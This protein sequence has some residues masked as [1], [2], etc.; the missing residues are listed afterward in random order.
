MAPVIH[1][2]TPCLNTR[3]SIDRTILSV[4]TQAGDFSIRYHIQDGGSSDGNWERVQWWQHKMSSE[5][6]PIQCRHINLTCA[7][8]DDVGMYDAIIKG[9]DHTAARPNDFLT[10]INAD[11]V[12]LPGALAFVAN[13]DRQFRPK[14][15]AWLGGAVSITRHQEFWPLVNYDRFVSTDAIKAGLCDGIHLDFVQ[16]EG[17]FYRKWLW[18]K[19]DPSASLRLMKIGGDWNAWRLMA[20]HA[21][22]HQTTFPLGT[23]SIREGQL[24][25]AFR[26]T[27]MSEIDSC[28]PR[29]LRR[30]DFER[31]CATGYQSRSVFFSRFAD[32][33][34]RLE[35]QAET[36]SL[37]E[38][39]KRY[40]GQA[41]PSVECPDAKTTLVGRTLDFDANSVSLVSGHLDGLSFYNGRWQFPATTEQQAYLRVLDQIRLADDLTYV[42]FPWATLIDK[43]D[44]RSE[45]WTDFYASFRAFVASIPSE[46]RRV[47]V[48]QHVNM[49]AY[50][51]LF[52]EAGIK[53][54][55]WSHANTK[56][57]TLGWDDGTQICIHPFPLFPVQRVGNSIS[58]PT[59]S[60]YTERR[61]LFS[62]IGAQSN[63]YYPRQT[64]NAILDLLGNDSRGYVRGREIWFYQRVVYEHQVP[65]ARDELA[66]IGLTDEEHA[67]EFLTVLQQSIF[68]LCPAGTGPNSI[69]LWESMAL[70]AIPVV[71]AD[72]WAPPGNR[73]LW[74]AAVIFRPETPEAVAALP[75]ELE[76]VARDPDFL[77]SKRH[78]IKQL[79][80]LYGPES[81]VFDIHKLAQR[82]PGSAAG[83]SRS[84]DL[85]TFDAEHQTMDHALARHVLTSISAALLL[86]DAQSAAKLDD[87]KFQSTV[88][89]AAKS[90]LDPNDPVLI[91]FD[92]VTSM[93]SDR[94][95]SALSYPMLGKGVLPSIHLFGP[96][97][98]RTPLSY[99]PIL[100]EVPQKL[101]FVSDPAKAD[102]LLTGFNR[103]FTEAA[104][105]IE[106]L[107]TKRPLIKLLVLSEEPFWDTLWS[108][109]FVSK[110]R[111]L[112]NGEHYRFLNYENSDIFDFRHLPY[113]PLTDDDLLATY[114]ARIEIAGKKQPKELLGAWQKA[115]VPLAFFAEHRLG[116][117]FHKADI[118]KDIW[119]LS[120]PRTELAQLC[121]E[122]A[123]DTLCVGKGWKD[124][125]RRQDLPNWHLDKL[126][127]LT[128]RT[129][130]CSAIENT[131]HYRYVTE[132]IFDAFAVGAIPIY[133]ASNTHRVFEFVP[134]A[135][136]INIF[137]LDAKAAADAVLSFTPDV[138]VAEAWVETAK[139]L[140]RLFA[141]IRLI[142]EERRRV[143]ERC[144]A[145]VLEVI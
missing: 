79:L 115:P 83:A 43:I 13:V 85:I 2:V 73:A 29:N 86:N 123:G 87:P 117:T 102:I 31:Y 60:A 3:D 16:Q 15:V 19:I 59:D 77:A 50:L 137:G 122:R 8:E 128:D 119:T 71:M 69:R 100:R 74:D 20:H 36:L 66:A 81:F 53:E 32:G 101:R 58:Q 23:F 143:A 28:L 67:T 11:D 105:E 9:Y 7:Q 107:H 33:Q 65:A 84:P 140:A 25:R 18:D 39:Y 76:I 40:C 94:A 55:F 118:G 112:S 92:Q 45:D 108:D 145:A 138:H 72:D 113:F 142:K 98:N 41:L 51:D 126:A 136:M 26:E 80:L 35:E 82:S 110:N 130:I 44:S 144:L 109:G 93:H 4:I 114:A 116:K 10:W 89:A 30:A 78:A 95:V 90:V 99:A 120:T 42:A 132:K 37:S 141:D 27:Y 104:Q 61:Y 46:N 5:E 91:H 49:K 134:P 106:Q 54:I 6:F 139:A 1:V 121:A 47:T 17:T 125:A 21:T 75:D 56:E 103:D 48:C 64:R 57:A 38:A 12:L 129:Q 14:D 70:G 88:V 131:H 111:R 135:A 62:F 133:F 34:L 124:D 63:S 96:H 68:S 52:H 22:Y 127:T 97:S 24:S